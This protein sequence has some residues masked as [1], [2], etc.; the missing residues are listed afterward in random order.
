M[1]QIDFSNIFEQLAAA[2]PTLIGLGI[3]LVLLACG[4]G[5]PLPEDVVLVFTGYV[6]HLGVLPV[7][8]SLF[9]G[10]GGVLLGDS[11]LWWIGHRYGSDV[12][13]LRLFRS[14][15]PP[16]RL[17][18]IERLYARYGNRILFGARFSPG[19]RA[20]VFLFGGLSGV[21]Y[22]RFILTDGSA[23][24]ISVPAIILAAYLFGGEIERVLKAMRGVQHW[25]VAAI[26]LIV[27]GH[28]IYA[29]F[30]RRKERRLLEAPTAPA[31]AAAAQQ[32]P[33]A[34]GR[35]GLRSSPVPAS[36]DQPSTP[37]P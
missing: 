26:V 37:A 25:L 23:A 13:R 5:L 7:W 4:F 27:V 20:G 22:R 29:W 36:A 33:P 14:F 24:L 10:L 19:I 28:L 32:P 31:D 18:K 21:P 17:L 30:V 9:I 12:L 35:T 6:T 8:L 1:W 11:T 3:F 15:L 16:A 34:S 2:D